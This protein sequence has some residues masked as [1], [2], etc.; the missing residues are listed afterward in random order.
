MTRRL[1]F[2]L[3]IAATMFN[4]ELVTYA[5]CRL[6]GKV[7]DLYNEPCVIAAMMAAMAP[8]AVV[9]GVKTAKAR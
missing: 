2:T 7:L 1:Q 3:W 4:A 6:L 5:G 8:C 9:I